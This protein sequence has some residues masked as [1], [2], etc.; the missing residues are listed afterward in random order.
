MN[1]SAT[2]NLN[3]QPVRLLAHNFKANLA[4]MESVRPE[5]ADAL[6]EL[7]PA[8]EYAV[9]TAGGRITLGVRPLAVAGSSSSST[10]NYSPLP[11]PVSPEQARGIVKQICPDG[12]YAQPVLVAGLDYGWL[13]HALANLPSTLQQVP[14]HRP[15][16]YLLAGQIER[17]WV[18]LHLHDWRKMLADSRVQLFVGTDA[19]EQLK[20]QM[21][22]QRQIPWPR[23]CATVDP[24]LWP[25]KTNLDKLI[26]DAHKAANRELELTQAKL[27]AAYAWATYGALSD[28]IASGQPLKIMGITSRYTTFLQHSMRDWLQAFE[29]LGHKTQ[30]V[31]EQGDHQLLTNLSYATIAMDFQPDLVV[32]IDHFRGEMGGLPEEVPCAMWVQDIL[33]NIFNDRSAA[34]QTR[35][36]YCL[37]FA[38]LEMVSKHGYPFGRYLPATVGCNQFKFAPRASDDSELEK[39]ACDI[40]FVSHASA[41][42]EQILHEQLATASPETRRVMEDVFGQLKAV[43]D[44]G[45]AIFEPQHMAGLINHSLQAT[46]MQ[47]DDAT[48][49]QLTGFFMS[50]INNALFRH[51]TLEWAA[52]LGLD[53]RL[54]GRGWENHPTLGKYARGVAQ[55]TGQLQAIY[56]A[57]RI[58][59]QITPSGAVHQRLF[60][61][62]ASGGFTLLRYCPGDLV[63]RPY[64]ILWDW[65][66]ENGI[67][68]DEQIMSKATP[69]VRQALDEYAR[70][71]GVSPFGQGETLMDLLRLSAD[72]EFSRSASSIFTDYDRVSFS[73][74][75]QLHKLIRHFLGSEEDRQ[76]INRR[77]RKQVVPRFT[78]TNVSQRLLSLIQ[79]DLAGEQ[80]LLKEVAA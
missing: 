12:N 26:T 15:P 21:H 72:T 44:A 51:Q 47:V 28:K 8:N 67:Q 11:N 45:G 60:E 76:L 46:G 48:M 30:L 55:H 58:N 20:H 18:I 77:M 37:G 56:Q 39:F 35:R 29:A 23:M 25:A 74:R 34:M 7:S 54:Y 79:R 62:V 50:R 33:P 63:E 22:T 40:S 65:V 19:V 38:R 68:T 49:G 57:S 42:G 17:L 9:S 16:L 10:A 36:D 59:L 43:Y 71:V 64:R 14:G 24:T 70:I 61:A 3:W 5:L 80:Q 32:V 2:D 75:D 6:R 66:C 13:W 41:S 73:T 52:E 31:I 1:S 69:Q 4:A 78:Y 53:L 27:K